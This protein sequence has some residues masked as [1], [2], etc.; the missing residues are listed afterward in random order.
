M[1]S[2]QLFGVIFMTSVF[3]LSPSYA[4]LARCPERCTCRQRL[5]VV[6]CSEAGFTAIPT[7][8]TTVQALILD[9]NPLVTLAPDVFCNATET[10]QLSLQ[11]CQLRSI[12]QLAFR[13]MK[14]LISLVLAKNSL[15]EL[16]A[17]LL[18]GNNQLENLV[19]SDNKFKISSL[20]PV[21]SGLRNLK[22]LD[23][24]NNIVDGESLPVEF[25]ELVRLKTLKLDKVVISEL[26]AGYLKPLA[27]L[28]VT[29]LV[30]SGNLSNI[31]QYALSDMT[32]LETLDVS[33]SA[34]MSYDAAN[35][36]HGL[37]NSTYL[38]VL[39]MDY[40][41][42]R[43]KTNSTI[44]KHFFQPLMSTSLKVIHFR[45]NPRAFNGILQ[46]R[47]FKS[48]H[49]LTEL[50]LDSCALHA[51]HSDALHGLG[52]LN[53]LSLKSNFLTCYDKPVCGFLMN[54]GHEFLSNLEILDLSYNNIVSSPDLVFHG[55]IFPK[56]QTLA[57]SY[58]RLNR[59]SDG[60]FRGLDKLRFLDLA[61]NPIG[62]VEPEVFSDLSQL[63]TLHVN[64][65]DV[66][67]YLPDGMFE[68][69]KKLKI[70]DLADGDISEVDPR[71]F[72][73]LKKLEYLNLRNNYL[74]AT[75]SFSN[76]TFG[77]SD[78]WKLDLG[79][80][81]LTTLPGFISRLSGLQELFLDNNYLQDD[82][83][84]GLANNTVLQILDLSYNSITRVDQAFVK[85]HPRLSKVTM[86]GNPFIC[87][88]SLHRIGDSFLRANVTV[89]NYQSHNC[90]IPQSARGE[91]IFTY[92]P[93][94]WNCGLKDGIVPIVCV[95][96]TL[97]VC[98]L[99]AIV[100]R[101]GCDRA[102]I[103]I[104]D[105]CNWDNC[106][107]RLSSNLEATDLNDQDSRL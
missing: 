22:M 100:R 1:T 73:N 25:S 55:R 98:L 77:A 45:G 24:G 32:S 80:N 78:L 46:H 74:G 86:E 88:C 43:P 41:F 49:G 35:L 27:N 64:S 7:I 34:M 15:S 96:C 82:S 85:R 76:A 16:P 107:F 75:A 83:V 44:H 81:R 42:N 99:A 23:L 93:S 26:S 71:A 62:V 28:S 104:K 56:L 90:A 65:T 53:V 87:D 5:T 18:V 54:K 94:R 10:R 84:L 39:N 102:R 19:L 101:V 11:N 50:Y 33:D 14:R 8:P 31:S 12:S 47:L 63:T 72:E 29:E 67:H 36:L 3:L 103:Q 92:K 9:N 58:N 37:K 57:L 97:L 95:L 60:L 4:G 52:H 66:L 38:T 69:C 59:L 40:V 51:V 105:F 68:G 61:G 17:E 6:D 30:I 48:L 20:A 89:V 21:I 2:L 79:Y 91:T 13:G 70:L 106:Y